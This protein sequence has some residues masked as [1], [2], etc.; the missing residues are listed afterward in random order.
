MKGIEMETDPLA[1]I[2]EENRLAAEAYKQRKIQ[3]E[4]AAA[5]AGQSAVASLEEE[6]SE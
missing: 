6:V 4:K 5:L 2:R 3:E 1:R